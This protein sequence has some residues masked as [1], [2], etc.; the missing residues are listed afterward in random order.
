[1]KEQSPWIDHGPSKPCPF[2][3]PYTSR[4]D[5][6]LRDGTEVLDT[7]AC[8]TSWFWYEHD[9]HGDDVVAYRV[10]AQA[11]QPFPPPAV[12]MPL[13]IPL[14]MPVMPDEP[15]DA[16]DDSWMDGYNAAL[17]M[18]EQCVR[19]I[20]AAGQVSGP[21][22]SQQLTNAASDVLAER[23]RQITAEGW[24]LGHDDEHVEGQMAD[25][26]GCYAH[27]AAGWNNY[28]ARDRWP[29]SLKWWKPSTP[30]RN[31]IKA[32]ALILAEIER[33]DRAEQAKQQEQQP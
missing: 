3:S 30:R 18:R 29:W 12:A 32:G 8:N 33:L 27:A 11:A 4:V 22:V 20:E 16:I 24:A 13:A 6:R 7:L 2:A 28:S 1:M 26:A 5:I 25:A 19:A 21:V 17:R 10:P 15:E 23:Q 14:P 9:K 31:L